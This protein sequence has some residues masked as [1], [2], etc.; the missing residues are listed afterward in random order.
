MRRGMLRTCAIRVRFLDDPNLD[1]RRIYDPKDRT[2]GPLIHVVCWAGSDLG[3]LGGGFK[4]LTAASSFC[5]F[6]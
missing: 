3:V 4:G 2:E 6:C 1:G 5:K